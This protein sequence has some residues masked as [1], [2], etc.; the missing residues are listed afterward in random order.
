M[1]IPRAYPLPKN[2]DEFKTYVDT[3]ISLEL[4]QGGV[5]ELFEH[6]ILGRAAEARKHR[7]SVLDDVILPW[8]EA[9]ADDE[10]AEREAKEKD[11]EGAAPADS[12]E[13]DQASES[14]PVSED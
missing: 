5:D 12:S 1:K 7:W 13:T 9:A 6:W 2:Q 11:Q 8:L 4:G 14:A 10:E 3:W